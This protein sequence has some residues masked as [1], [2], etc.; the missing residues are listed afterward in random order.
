MSSDVTP[1]HDVTLWYHAVTSRCDVTPLW[2]H[3]WNTTCW[4]ML[5][6]IQGKSLLERLFVWNS[7]KEGM[8]REGA[9]TL[10]RFHYRCFFRAPRSVAHLLDYLYNWEY[11][12]LKTCWIQCKHS[13]KRN[14]QDDCQYVHDEVLYI[15]SRIHQLSRAVM[16]GWTDGSFLSL[17]CVM[18]IAYVNISLIGAYD[19]T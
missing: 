7:D 3:G 10:R 12:K 14:R 18:L 17:I 19:T 15:S 6:Y 5:C 8:S 1:W 4:K 16:H 13:L 2:R 11:W 9:P